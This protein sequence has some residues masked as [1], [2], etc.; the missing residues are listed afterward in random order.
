TWLVR[1]PAS[2]FTL[3]VRS[4][5]VPATGFISAWVPSFPS[6]PTSRALG[7]TWP[8]HARSSSAME[9]LRV[10]RARPPASPRAWIIRDST[11]I[12]DLA[13]RLDG[14]LLRQVAVGDRG[15][16]ERDVAHLVGQVA[17]EHV[18]GV[19]QLPPGAGHPGHPGL[20]AQLPLDAH[21]ARHRGDLL[22]E[23]AQRV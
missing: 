2:R 14:D 12:G 13:A 17:G 15:G 10:G 11:E 19:G 8:A 4:F 9:E 1:L 21:L 5:Q 6:V 3:S 22:G 23:R 7:V 20:A 18:D 16:D